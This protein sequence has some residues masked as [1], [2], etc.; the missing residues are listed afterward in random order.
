MEGTATETVEYT[1][2]S[3]RISIPAKKP[4][5]EHYH[6]NKRIDDTLVEMLNDHFKVKT[7]TNATAL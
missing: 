6:L 1:V 3:K 7:I 4:I 5:W 2:S